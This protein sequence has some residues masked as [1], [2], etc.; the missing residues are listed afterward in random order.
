MKNQHLHLDSDQISAWLIGERT[1][2]RT[3]HVNECAA[4]R[5]EIARLE[6]AVTSFRESVERWS[7]RQPVH[8]AVWSAPS[9]GFAWRWA[10]VAAMFLLLV[11]IPAY[12]MQESKNQEMAERQ[13]REDAALMEAVNN[14]I[15]RS[16]PQTLQPLNNMV[17]WENASQESKP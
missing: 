5:A 4:C 15:A 9:R 12:R 8:R 3:A 13:A 16:V 17:S 11:G 6:S 14:G 2:E 1:P 10:A 7:E